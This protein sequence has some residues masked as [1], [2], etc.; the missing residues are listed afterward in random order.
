MKRSLICIFLLS[1]ML[2]WA[3]VY[4]VLT[5]A[6]NNEIAHGISIKTQIPISVDQQPVVHIEGYELNAG[7]ISLD[8]GW[9]AVGGALIYAGSSSSGSYAP[10]ISVNVVSGKIQIYIGGPMDLIYAPR[11]V[12]TAY[13]QGLSETAPMFTGW[14]VS[15]E[16][17]TGSAGLDAY[18]MLGTGSIGIADNM[19]SSTILTTHIT[20]G[21]KTILGS[22]SNLDA[23]E[24]LQVVG[25]LGINGNGNSL[26]FNTYNF[27][28]VAKYSPFG[29][30]AGKLQLDTDGK[31]VYSNTA[32]S[33]TGGT[34]ATLNNKFVITKEG[35]LG[36]SADNPKEMMQVNGSIATVGND[37]SLFFNAYNNSGKKF[38]ATGYAAGFTL[39]ANGLLTYANTSSS[40]SADAAA[41]LTNVF[42]INKNGVVGI[43]TTNLNDAG[44][45]LFVESGV[46]ARKVKVDQLT[47]SDYVFENNYK[48]RPLQEVEQFIV[49]NKHLPDVPSA[50]QI[51]K[52]GNDL[53]E[54]QRILLQKIEEL[55]L[56]IIQQSKELIQQNQ[57]ILQQSKE[58]QQQ[59]KEN[60][61]QNEKIKVMEAKLKKEGML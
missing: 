7:P 23:Y 35:R 10:H 46:R 47:W 27:S 8:I 42:A 32:V 21:G 9:Y 49:K 43:G 14:T 12:V 1:P 41:T 55:T 60:A 39:D 20:A 4:N 34:N 18:S 59:Q 30:Y 52:D 44:Y 58:L 13:A 29:G 6:N 22:N 40:G 11:F 2:I 45:K 36:I 26:K 54:T 57:N 50:E 28:G 51:Q 33:G 61:A 19:Q 17:R 38:L 53:G 16:V 15:D 25:N 5:Y 24:T 56:Y 3:Q 48:L 31:L 37:K